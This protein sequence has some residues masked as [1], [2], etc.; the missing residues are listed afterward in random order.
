MKFFFLKEHGL[1]KIFKTLEKVPARKTIHINIDPEHAFFENERRAAQLKELL[2]KKEIVAFFIAKTQRTKNFFE[3]TNLPYIFQERHPIRKALH[4]AKLFLFD[5]KR[6]HLHAIEKKNYLF[7]VVFGA[8]FLFVALIV[9][10]LYTLIVP[11][12]NIQITPTYQVEDITYN[13]RYYPASDTEYPNFSRYLNIP[14]YSWY[15]DHNYE[16]TISANNIRHIQN[17]S[18]WTITIHNT[19]E[20]ELSLIANTRFITED[21]LFFKALRAFTI[22]AGSSENPS[23]IDIDVEAMEFDDKN[24][25]IGTR[26]NIGSGTQM[27]IRNITKSY[28][29]KEIYA[30]AKTD[31]QWGASTSTWFLTQEDVSILSGKLIE[32]IQKNTANIITQNFRNQD[33]FF[34]NFPNLISYE[35]N[36]ITIQDYT[37]QEQPILKGTISARIYFPFVRRADFNKVIML[38]TEQRPS[39]KTNVISID[40][41]S[42]V[43]YSDIK[44]VDDLFIIPTKISV[45]QWYD[46]QTDINK[47]AENIKNRITGLRTE[48]ARE[49][50]L[51]YPEISTARIVIRPP[52]YTTIPTLKSRINLRIDTPK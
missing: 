37:K 14:F 51:S 15:L 31:F 24:I 6:F 30:T 9:L 35:I 17:P 12:A 22:P 32:H 44:T 39:E 20:D 48:Q 34:I 36:N 1:Y 38:Y 25:I 45:I 29:T 7:F 27:R 28:F 19:T 26:G 41:N 23:Q 5:I 43:F 11:S 18:K 13:F 3:R 50:I 52:R 4:I 40:R 8:E 47:V 46:F 10:G 2:D 21:G 42:L 49:I 16:L 33:A